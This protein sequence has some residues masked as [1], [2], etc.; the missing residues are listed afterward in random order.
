MGGKTRIKFR[1]DFGNHWWS[2][3]DPE[4]TKKAVNDLNNV[5]T[6]IY[7]VVEY[8]D[9]ENNVVTINQKKLNEGEL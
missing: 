5:K 7:H 8:L 6:E 9:D 3:D 2:F 1:I 4:N